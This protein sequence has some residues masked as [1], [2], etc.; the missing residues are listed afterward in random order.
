MMGYVGVRYAKR[1]INGDSVPSRMDTGA[2]FVNAENINDDFVQLM[3]YPDGK[4]DA[5][6]NTTGGEG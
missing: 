1:A 3:I 4:P 5:A 2:V 6:E